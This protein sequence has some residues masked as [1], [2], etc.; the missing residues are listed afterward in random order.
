MSERPKPPAGYVTWL[1]YVLLDNCEN[2]KCA[3][4][5]LA[6]LRARLAKLEAVR[7]AAKAAVYY[8]HDKPTEL[9]LR[10]AIDAAE[11]TTDEQG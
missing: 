1:D 2:D 6:E 9:A 4:V 11:R 10:A 5:E 7:E 3:R 8:L